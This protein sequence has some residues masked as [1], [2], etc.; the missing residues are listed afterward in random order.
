MADKRAY[1][2]VD[3]GYF[4]NPK[5]AALS[6]ERPSAV[7]LHLASIGYG[8]QHLTDGIVP[9][10]LLLRLTGA[11]TDDATALVE[12]DVWHRDGHECGRCAQPGRGHVAVHD[13]LEHQ[14][15]AADVKRLSA[16]GAAGAA[17][18]WNANG[19][20]DRN[21]DGNGQPNAKANGQRE[22]EKEREKIA[23]RER[24]FAEF[25]DLYPLKKAK[26]AAEKAYAK[27]LKSATSEEV[28]AGLR[29]Q[30]PRMTQGDPKF[31][32]HPTTWLNQGRWADEQEPTSTRGPLSTAPTALPGE[33]EYDRRLRERIPEGW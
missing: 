18:R 26:V 23:A 14:R 6:I 13:F 28:L 30:L 15:S 9:E 10:L 32:P 24:A 16:A 27:A 17:G 25:W 2:K 33:T 7:I 31:I 3:V 4:T 22:R 12:A 11:T 5:T 20:T 8:A 29:A 1:F 19:N 21:A